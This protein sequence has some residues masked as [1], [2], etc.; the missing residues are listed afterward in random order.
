MCV[1]KA[2][3]VRKYCIVSVHHTIPY[4]CYMLP[5]C[6]IIG[7]CRNMQQGVHRTNGTKCPYCKYSCEYGMQVVALDCLLQHSNQS[8][9]PVSVLSTLVQLAI[10]LC[11]LLFFILFFLCLHACRGLKSTTQGR[12]LL[13]RQLKVSTYAVLGFFYTS[14]TQAILSI[15]SCYLIDAPIPSTTAY[16]QN[17]QA[18]QP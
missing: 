7:R 11:I 6:S 1:Q 14:L 5:D 13:H 15:F 8:A 2:D 16:P 4:S 12:T 18:S 9:I 10:P 3:V 17:L